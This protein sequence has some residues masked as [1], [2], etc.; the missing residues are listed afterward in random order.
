MKPYYVVYKIIENDLDLFK[1]EEK[2]RFTIKEHA[3]KFIEE[4]A[5]YEKEYLIMEL[6]VKTLD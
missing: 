6:Y 4:E 5:W 2:G 3:V 1:L